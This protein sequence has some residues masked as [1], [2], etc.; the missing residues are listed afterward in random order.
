MNGLDWVI[1]VAGGICILRG[2]WRGAVSQVFGI[3]GV[4]GGFLLASRNY[5]ALARQ[6]ADTFPK[7]G[8]APVL[9][10][11]LIFFL[12]WLCVGM[13]GYFLGKLLR[14]TGFGFLDRLLGGTVG[15]AKAGI[16]AVI[17]VWLLTLFLPPESPHLRRS[18]LLPYV[19]QFARILVLAT[20]QRLQDQF[21][22]KRRE[23]EKYWSDQSRRDPKPS[24][25][26]KGKEKSPHEEL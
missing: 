20:P 5:E 3:A 13:L 21:D 24:P 22:R 18:I 16:L 19:H 1:V 9:S 12:T 7:V 8:V 17:L 11:L 10:F 4:L 6:I 15:L 26:K 2:I 14:L 23:I 25:G